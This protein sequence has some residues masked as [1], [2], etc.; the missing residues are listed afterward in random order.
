MSKNFVLMT[1]WANWT[2]YLSTKAVGRR[3]GRESAVTTSRLLP[4]LRAVRLAA[5]F[6]RQ[7]YGLRWSDYTRREERQHVPPHI[8]ALQDSKIL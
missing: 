7:G 5:D 4:V 2:V 6:N 8:A 1:T 3:H